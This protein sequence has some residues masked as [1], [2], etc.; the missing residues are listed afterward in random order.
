M[1]LLKSG[2]GKAGFDFTRLNA[3][4]DEQDGSADSW[5]CVRDNVTG[6]VWEVKADDGSFQDGGFTYSWYSEEVNGG[7]EG[8]ETGANA[9]CLLTNCNT[10]AYVAAV[11]A[12]G[13]CGFMI[14]DC[15]LTT[16]FS[17]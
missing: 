15:L 1:V 17:R 7:F 2:R 11:N 6:L 10:S 12:Q 16:S 14:G 5:S 4:G 3:N 9:T 13:L 8:D